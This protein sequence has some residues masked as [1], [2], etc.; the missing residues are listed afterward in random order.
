MF[1]MIR[2]TCLSAIASLIFVQATSATVYLGVDFP[3]GE[4]SFADAVL[5]HDPLFSGGPAP[6]PEVNDPTQA[7]GPPPSGPRPGSNRY[8]SM[9]HGGL[10]ELGF[11]NNL[12]SNSGDASPDMMVVEETGTPERFYLALRPTAETLPL[13]DPARDTN[14]DGYFEVGR[15]V[16]SA[17]VGQTEGNFIELIDLDSVFAGFSAFTL[18]FDAVQIMDDP[19]QGESDTASVGMDLKA[20][21]AIAAV[22][23]EPTSLAIIS[24]CLAVFT[25][26][27]RQRRLSFGCTRHN[28]THSTRPTV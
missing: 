8:V 9:G 18:T 3:L 4:R 23:P 26:V 24:V 2:T 6:T 13:L 20:V 25:V 28:R 10:I 1:S 15:F 19:T 21:G 7:L 27:C 17:T 16:G 11:V 12:Q 22:V 5:R 14:A